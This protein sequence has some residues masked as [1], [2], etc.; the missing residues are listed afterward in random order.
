[1]VMGG[2]SCSEGQGFK[3]QYPILDEHF[4]QIFGVK[5]VMKRKSCRG[6]GMAH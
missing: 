1:M 3:S 6:M 4:S 2:D 5:I